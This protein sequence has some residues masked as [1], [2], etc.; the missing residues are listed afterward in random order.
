MES[1]SSIYMKKNLLK[2]NTTTAAYHAADYDI[3]VIHTRTS[4]AIWAQ[5]GLIFR[6]NFCFLILFFKSNGV[7]FSPSS[8]WVLVES[9][10]WCL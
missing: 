6:D 2:E 8:I 3:V 9:N 1:M 7:L 4:E 10:L 5:F